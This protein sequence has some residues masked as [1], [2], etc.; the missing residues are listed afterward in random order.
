[1]R[2]FD[3]ATLEAL[4]TTLRTL[5]RSPTV[6]GH[7]LSASVVALSSGQIVFDQNGGTLLKPASNTKLFTTA[8][9][10]GILG[11]DWRPAS[12]L[13]SRQP[14]KGDTI[15]GDLILHGVHDASWSTLFYPIP[16]YVAN[17][18]VDQ[19]YDSGIRRIDGDLLVHGLFV[20]DGH[21]FGTL[22]TATERLQ[23]ASMF[24]ERL[25]AKG[26]GLRGEVKISDQPLPNRY[27]HELARWEGPSLPTIAA[28][29]NRI[30]HNEF[31]DML[32]LAIAQSAGE[33]AGYSNGFQ[34]METWLDSVGVA[35]DGLRLRDGSGLSHDNRVTAQQLV[36]LIA[37]VQNQPWADEWNASLSVA[38]MDG[39]Y[40]NRM[41]GASTRGCAWLKSGT[42]NGV[43][44]TAGILHHRGTGERYAVAFVMNEVR[45]QPSARSSQDQLMAAVGD[46][47]F[48]AAR[49]A[50]PEL[51]SATLTDANEVQLRWSP[52]R[53]SL[54]YIIESRDEDSAWQ[55]TQVVDA[56]QQELRLPRGAAPRAYRILAANAEGYSDPSGVLIAGG[57]RRAERVLVVDGNERWL[58]DPAPENGL[59]APHGF[60]AQYLAPLTGYR[61]ESITNRALPNHT[62][63]AT[64]T[65]LFALGEEA[66]ATEA[67]SLRERQWIENHLK[68]GGSV[69]V[70]GSEVAWDLATN[71]PEGPAFLDRVFGAAFVDDNA[72]NTVACLQPMAQAESGANSQC[73]HFWTPGW[74]KIEW[75]DVLRSTRGE[76]CMHYGGMTAEACVVHQRAAL[77]GFP[78]E[79]IDNS[80]D[81]STVVRQ[82]I[83]RVS[84]GG[85]KDKS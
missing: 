4:H 54:H 55:T 39:T 74:M 32:M 51:Q 71:V 67:L 40:G 52:V 50:T 30:S 35:H 29:I 11:A 42:I 19:L 84:T 64:E 47:Y 63:P 59:R 8:A 36:A 76:T 72:G 73:A 17:R 2:A 38:G 45:H 66:R 5:L 56:S 31:A 68:Q 16:H 1:M 57:P 28:H 48:S 62:S 37:A 81:R 46:T 85:G 53:Q 58:A 6:A 12:R 60:L 26:I 34:A 13:L 23:A 77:V 21:R 22:N 3:E 70:A 14:A 18:L 20:V 43:I 61:V 7:T 9:A 83:Q 44:S 80:Q 65:V 33:S 10:F 24:R 49:P 82:L 15:A 78:L 41:H 27:P 79:S 69:I 25:R 75:P